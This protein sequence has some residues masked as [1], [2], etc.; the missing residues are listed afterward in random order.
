MV[1]QAA[2]ESQRRNNNVG[3]RQ[4]WMVAVEDSMRHG[5]AV[6]TQTTLVST[7][8]RRLFHPPRSSPITFGLVTATRRASRYVTRAGR[9]ARNLA[10]FSSRLVVTMSSLWV[11]G[12][13]IQTPPRGGEVDDRRRRSDDSS[14]QSD[15]VRVGRITRYDLFGA[16]KH[17]R[18]SL[19]LVE[20]PRRSSRQRRDREQRAG[21]SRKIK[22]IEGTQ[23]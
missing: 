6:T 11:D 18:V 16:K 9:A 19:C 21:S 5:N 22:K 13:K 4:Q 12:A 15:S 7:P 8:T 14:D 20:I 23:N 1:G 3:G 2:S 17:P 10:T